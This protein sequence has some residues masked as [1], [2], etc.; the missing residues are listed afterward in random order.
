MRM[1]LIFGLAAATLMAA[2]AAAT[3]RGEG[4]TPAAT[5]AKSS[6]KGEK[7]ICRR[8]ERPGSHSSDKICLTKAQW[9]KIE[10]EG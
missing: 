4:A 2:P 5:T 10:R 7:K 6:D 3:A 8:Y 9:D 1:H